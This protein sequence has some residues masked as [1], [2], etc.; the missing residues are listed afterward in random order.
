MTRGIPQSYGVDSLKDEGIMLE[1]ASL[2][3]DLAAMA[4]PWAG[5]RFMEL[6]AR[7][8]HLASFGAMVQDHARGSVHAGPAGRRHPLRLL[9]PRSRPR[10]ARG[11]A[12]LR[13]FLRAGAR[14]VFPFIHRHDEL[15][16]EADLQ[17]LRDARLSPGDIEISAYHPLGTCRMGT[18]WKRSCVGPDGEAHDTAGLV[19]ADGSA[20][21]SSLGVNPQITI[22]ALALRAAAALDTRLARPARARLPAR[23]RLA[24]GFCETMRGA[25]AFDGETRERTIEFT[26]EA[27]AATL[28]DFASSNEVSLRG[29]LELQGLASARAVE[30][31]MRI[32]PLRDWR[33]EY[34]VQFQDDAGKE[35]RLQGHKTLRA[36]A[37]VESMTVLPVA[38]EDEEG[39]VAAR[40]TMRFKLGELPAFLA[41]FRVRPRPVVES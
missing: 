31:T 20:L 22:M 38:L 11:C 2:P 35:W 1:G 27:T 6:M 3:L 23:E 8:P 34:R 39:R 26:V 40:G 4:I 41:S 10:P 29:T 12:G 32:D 19:V 15:R 28:R 37:P 9:P 13:D 36:L 24:F 5:E 33:I 30:G 14:R 7:Y 25:L 18:D 16:D 17:R 21:P